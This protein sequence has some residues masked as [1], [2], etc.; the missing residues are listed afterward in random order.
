M[1]PPAR[2][3]ILAALLDAAMTEVSSTAMARGSRDVHAHICAD[4]EGHA[5]DAERVLNHLIGLGRREACIACEGEKFSCIQATQLANMFASRFEGQLVEARQF[6]GV[7]H[8]RPVQNG[9]GKLA[10]DREAVD[11]R[12]RM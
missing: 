10:T 6:T 4:A 11:A 7:L 8:G 3:I 1:T 5:E 9:R 2:S 12:K